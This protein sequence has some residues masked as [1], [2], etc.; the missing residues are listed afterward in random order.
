LPDPKD[1]HVLAVAI[2]TQSALIV[3]FNLKDFPQSVLQPYEIEAVLPDE[4]VVRLIQLA[5]RPVLQAARNHRSDLIRPPKTVDEYHATLEKQG[6]PKTV[7]FLRE[8]RTD[9]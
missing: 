4:F 2:H 7:A 8:H 3:T 5:P 6:L 9:I 1:R